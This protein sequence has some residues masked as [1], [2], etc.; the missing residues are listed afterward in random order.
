[1]IADCNFLPYEDTHSFSKMAMDYVK[2]DE[3]LQPFYQHP[4]SIDGV[5]AAIKDRQQFATNR[6]VLVTELRKQYQGYALTELQENNLSQLLNDNSFTITT[7]HQP[8][9]FTG[10]LYFVYKILHAIQ[11]TKFY[12]IGRAHV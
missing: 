6:K 3:K 5:K 12:K 1:M 2:G 11:L 4:V 8:N 10:H 9:I 7:A